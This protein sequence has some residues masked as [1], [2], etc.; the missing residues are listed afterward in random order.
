M[1]RTSVE[2]STSRKQAWAL[3]Y[4]LAAVFATLVFYLNICG[5]ATELQFRTFRDGSEALV[6][7]K[8]A[9]DIAHI[10]TDRANLGF[11][12]KDFISR[13]SD[14]LAVYKRLN[15]RNAVVPENLTDQNWT[16]GVSKFDAI[17]LL[18]RTAVATL[19]YAGNELLAGQKIRF[20]NGEERTVVKAE[21]NDKYILVYYSG[22]ALDGNSIGFPHRIDVAGEVER[23]RY[24]FEPYK[25]QYGLQGLLYSWTYQ[26]AGHLASVDFLQLLTAALFAI[27]LALLCYEYTLSLSAWF[28]VALFVSMVGSPWVVSVVRNLYWVAFL[29]ILPALSSLWIYRHNGGIAKRVLLFAAFFLSIFLKSLCG[30]EYLPTIVIFSLAIFAIAPFAPNPKYDFSTSMRFMAGLF[31]L[32]IAAFLCALL[33]HASIRAPS[34]IEGLELTYKIDAFKYSP[35]SAIANKA[36]GL[37]KSLGDVIVEYVFRWPTPVL[38]DIAGKFVFPALIAAALISVVCQYAIKDPNRKRD[39]A[40]LVAT[41]LAPCSWFLL[42]KGHS[43]I[44]THLNYVL[45][46]IG[47]IPALL[48]VTA[49][50]VSIPLRYAIRNLRKT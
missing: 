38:F 35:L 9:A 45:W 2:I 50:G 14:V 19:G 30:Y 4:S 36:M 40:L 37:E 16:N 26:S 5:T 21:P 24:V 47:F 7:G 17:F 6:L 3:A 49:R 48:F 39:S 22:T 18:P 46:Y 15:D 20:A 32:S 10:D 11:I 13:S 1:K 8:V 44:H 27:T 42:M 34:L 23:A 29:W 12:E 25:A 28:G 43:A 33:L 31:A 41:M